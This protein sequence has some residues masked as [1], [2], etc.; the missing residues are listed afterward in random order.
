MSRES[1]SKWL[2]SKHLISRSNFGNIFRN[3][4]REYEQWFR[5][6]EKFILFRFWIVNFWWSLASS[7]I[8]DTTRA[9]IVGEHRPSTHASSSCTIVHARVCRSHTRRGI[10]VSQALDY[11]YAIHQPVFMV[12]ACVLTATSSVHVCCVFVYMCAWILGHTHTRVVNDPTSVM[13]HKDQMTAEFAWIHDAE[14]KYELH[15]YYIER[16]VSV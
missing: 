10:V 1:N 11:S 2:L 13:I 12:K 6:T 14:I 4:W 8:L 15:M 7:N 3:L 16:N 5:E 9:R